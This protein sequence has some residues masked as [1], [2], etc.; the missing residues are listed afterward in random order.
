MARVGGEG[1]LQG[2][3]GPRSTGEGEMKGEL[4]L[5]ASPRWRQIGSTTGRRSFCRSKQRKPAGA[6]LAVETNRRGGEDDLLVLFTGGTTAR[7]EQ[8]GGDRAMQAR[9]QGDAGERQRQASWIRATRRK[10]GRGRA[11][12]R[13]PADGA[14]AELAAWSA[15]VTSS[16]GVRAGRVEEQASGTRCWRNSCSCSSKQKGRDVR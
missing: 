1:G 13:A 7:A 16:N 12:A 8:G 9:Q 3:A 6:G 5:G 14:A 2:H 4:G 10:T 15:M 11:R